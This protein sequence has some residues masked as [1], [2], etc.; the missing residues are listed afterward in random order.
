[1]KPDYTFTMKLNCCKHGI[2][3]FSLIVQVVFLNSCNTNSNHNSAKIGFLGFS[4]D[5]D[6]SKVKSAIDSLL[7]T[8]TLHYFETKDLLGTKQKN[9]YNNISIISPYLYAKVNL[10]GS[11]I[12]DER[13]TSI[14][15]TLCSRLKTADNAFSYN[16]ALNDLKSMFEL[17]KKKFGT[18]S[19]LDQ[20]EKYEWLAKRISEVYS[21]GPKGR[22]FMDRIFFWDK[23]N[24][25]IYFDFGYPENVTDPVNP[26]AKSDIHEIDDSTSAPIIYYDFTQDYIGILLDKASRNK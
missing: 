9:L 23:G 20:G 18:P 21:P 3:T 15:L 22:L 5:M 4:L 8:G 25:I 16:C 19:R 2:L 10:K 1:M 17:Y 24:Y 14:Q 7:N 12:I 11:D 26:S 13:L 6:Y